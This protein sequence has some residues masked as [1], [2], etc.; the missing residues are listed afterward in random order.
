MNKISWGIIGCGDVAEVKSGPAFQKCEHS[1]LL[2]VMRRD[3]EKAKDFASRHKVQ[4]WTNQVHEILNNP[5]INA[6]YIATPPSSHL[7]YALKALEAGKHVYL[8]KPMTLNL[9]EAL[10]LEIALKTSKS[11]LVVAHY[12]RKLPLF[13]KVKELLDQ[14]EIGNVQFAEIKLIQPNHDKLTVETPEDW[15]L[16]TEISGGGYF[17]DLAPHQLDLLI[18]FFGKPNQIDGFASGQSNLHT[19]NTTVNGILKFNNNIH[20]QGVWAFNCEVGKRKDSCVIY[21]DEGVLEFSF[22]GD[23]LQLIT[24][25]HRETF[26]FKN[27]KHVQQPMIQSAIHY[28][29][30]KEANPCSVTTGLE[31]MKIMEKFTKS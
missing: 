9:A 31:V 27:P 28:F 30:E 11:K 26:S 19:T 23:Q 24:K 5:K 20:F 14:N 15:R 6:V 21:G 22:F 4:H 2:S 3:L 1:E 29:L 10:Q 25:T 16:N 17:Y 7:D 8:E 12:R 13:L 18:H